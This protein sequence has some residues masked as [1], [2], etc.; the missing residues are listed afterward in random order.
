[1]TTPREF[2]SPQRRQA[3][4]R[5]PGRTRPAPPAGSEQWFTPWVQIRYFSFHPCIYPNMIA[6]ASPDAGAGSLVHVYDKNGDLFG[7]GL[8]NPSARTPLR[9]LHHGDQFPGEHLFEQRLQQALALRQQLLNLQATTNACRLVHSDGD[10]LS[11]LI[12]DRYADTLIADVHSLGMHQRLPRLLAT[13][14]AALGTTRHLVRVDETIAQIEGIRHTPVPLRPPTT[15]IHEH[16][17][18]YE[19][20]FAE[21]HK[22]GFFCDQRDNRQRLALYTPG[23]RVLDLC[24]YTGGFSLNAALRGQATEVTAVDLDEKA[25]AQARRNAHLNQARIQWTHVDAFTYARQMRQNHTRWDVVILDPPKLIEHRD[26]HEE[27]RRKYEDL[28]TLALGLVAPGGLF[29]TCSC[30]GLLDDETFAHTV[31]RAAHRQ[32]LRLQILDRTGAAPDHPILS[33]C[34]ESRY[35]KVLWTRLL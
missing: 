4:R 6:A 20:N 3:P 10:G 30:S 19:V 11:G 26:S 22:T 1:M 15:K 34:P 28:N 5:R 25:L 18:T 12:L 2:S 35:L 23:K 21:G 16:G 7:A 32:K 17:I 27:G 9:V 14:H 8:Y 33:N 24:C 31:Y 13:V 29:V